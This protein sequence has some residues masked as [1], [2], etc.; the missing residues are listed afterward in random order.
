[1]SWR[2]HRHHHH[3]RIMVVF[4]INETSILLTPNQGTV[5]MENLNLGQNLSL[6]IAF[7]DAAG[8]PMVT[9]PTPDAAP[10]WTQTTPATESLTPDSGGMT[11]QTKSLAVGSDSITVSVV[12]GGATFTATLAVNVATPAQVLTTVQIVPTVV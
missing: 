5:L 10:S 7:L 11:A 4:T 3:H 8:N 2:H 1:M 6:A 9:A 12:V